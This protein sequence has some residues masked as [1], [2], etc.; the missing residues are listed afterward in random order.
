MPVKRILVITIFALIFWIAPKSQDEYDFY[1]LDNLA[2]KAE[3]EACMFDLMDRMDAISDMMKQASSIEDV[4]SIRIKLSA[5]GMLYEIAYANSSD[6]LYTDDALMQLVSS[7]DDRRR[8]L[9]DSVAICKN[10]VNAIEASDKL[11]AYMQSRDSMYHILDAR[12]A[13][14]ALVKQAATILDK[15]KASEQLTFADISQKYEKAK[16]DADAFP[17]LQETFDSITVRYVA[18]KEMSD[19][20]QGQQYEPW[21]TRIK[22]YLISFA[23]VAIILMFLNVLQSKYKQAKMLRQQA[24]KLKNLPGQKKYPEI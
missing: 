21:L 18:I 17:Q 20:I 23:A 11:L 6:A 13:E 4:D 5:V 22:D 15:L 16:A 10:M 14:L 2:S 9:T 3:I 1:E 12:A 7:V 24:K 19:R 8:L